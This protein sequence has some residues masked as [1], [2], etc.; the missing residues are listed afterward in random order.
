MSN[1]NIVVRKNERSWAIEMISQ[2]NLIAD[3]NDLKIKRAGGESTISYNQ[4]KSMFPDV[5]LYGDKEL[6]S[7]LQGWELKMPDVPITDEVFIKDAQ[8]KAR[9]LQLNSCVIWNFTYAQFYVL[10]P[11]TD[12]FE[13]VKQWENLNIR[14]RQDVFTYQK[15]W[16]KTLSEII[17]EV[18]GYLLNGK[19]SRTTIGNVIAKGAINL[20]I[21]EN[22]IPVADFLKA[23]AVKN[24]IIK[25]NVSIWWNDIKA[26][27]TFD[28]EDM[29]YAYAKTIILNWAYRIIFAHLIKSR[30]VNASIIDSIDYDTTPQE[31]NQIFV[32]ITSKCDF[33]N[34]FESIQYGELLPE[35]TWQS[36]VE[37][38]LF[39]GE[40]GIK[41]IDQTLLQNIL[42]GSVNTTRREL[43]GQFTTP[44]TLARILANLTIHNWTENCADTCCGTGTIPHEILVAKKTKI[45]VSKAVETTWASDKYKMPLQIA[46]ISMTSFD[47]INMAN[48]LFQNNAFS[49]EC[50]QNIEIVNPQT[51]EI[52]SVEV[53]KFGAI[54]S[55]LPFVS[56][57][58]IP[59]DDKSYVYKIQNTHELDNK[60]DLSY[61]LAVHLSNLIKD[62]GYLGIITS[63][64][65][66]G[67]KSGNLFF[68]AI[69]KEYDLQ[70]VHISGNGRWFQNAD[71]VTTIL[72]LQKRTERIEK[73]NF[74]VWKVSLRTISQVSDY[75]RNIIDSS[76]VG[77]VV[78]ENVLGQSQYTLKQIE[79]LHDY[80]LSYNSLFHG[81]EWVL[82]I[83]H[84]LAPLQSLFTVIRGSRR[85]WDAMFFPTEANRIERDFILPALFNAKKVDHLIAT[86]DRA[87]FSCCLSIEEIEENYPGAYEWI[88]KFATQ[89]NGKKKP[90][91]EVLKMSKDIEWY[92]MQPNEVVEFFT[93]M[94]PD[95]RL[96]FGRFE[97]PSFINQRLIGLRLKN[98]DADAKLYH[99]LLNS[100]LIKFFIEAVG[101]GR[102][103]G[104]LDINKDNISKCYML[105]PTLLSEESIEDIK[106]A[107]DIILQKEIVSVEDETQDEDWIAFNHTILRAF[108]IDGYYNNICNSLRSLRK[109]RATA[110]DSSDKTV[111]IRRGDHTLY[112]TEEE[113]NGYSIAAEPEKPFM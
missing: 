1:P 72:I 16:A 46:N 30:Q 88:Q 13:V 38:S 8:R 33:Y 108:V 68:K 41:T 48:R 29:Y 28:E 31:A 82:D 7:I 107:F 76:L 73:I 50:G 35:Q 100:I 109:I 39:L 93:M 66:L 52:M 43:N 34:V 74:Y 92:E 27:Y 83:Q 63:N 9:A 79:S 98:A 75:E 4:G 102:G 47:T 90:L 67:T 58:N 78:N 64:A 32:Q 3:K 36:L 80:N 19:I 111:S 97:T 37:L 53:P 49:L 21:N 23:E 103:L 42:E 25:A 2:I 20:L 94:N 71:V 84:V 105:N 85:G 81:V 70:Q 54:C 110:K 14:T 62:D 113:G 51:G 56:F 91:P 12:K 40:N 17:I 89:R 99:A 22:K 11:D 5:I 26:E 45:G 61:Y 96:F 24:T 60:S 69:T 95:K 112:E 10:N 106:S 15:E 6:T 59:D 44:K 101:F 55:N 65:W 104:V 57:E 77:A 86:P 87:A 18:N